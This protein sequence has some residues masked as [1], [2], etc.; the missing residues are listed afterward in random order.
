MIQSE[1]INELAA[2]LSKA[3]AQ[4]EFAR[5]DSSNPFFKSK[6]ADLSSVWAACKKPLAENGLSIVQA[7]NF[8]EDK[9]DYV[10]VETQLNHA[11]GQWMRGKLVMKPV[12]ND[13]QAIG[14]CLSYARR[15][16][17]SAMIGVY[18]DDDDDGNLASGKNGSSSENKDESITIWMNN[19]KDFAESSS[20]EDYRGYWNDKKDEINHDCGTAGASKVYKFYVQIG[21]E[22]AQ[23][24]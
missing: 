10:C 21:K 8:L 22:K 4:M 24:K 19:I 17:L 20:I 2:A 11:S 14:S 5:K 16:S 3:Q 18:A 15:Y 7:C 23:A 13:P 1:S 9:P 12:K 6:Y